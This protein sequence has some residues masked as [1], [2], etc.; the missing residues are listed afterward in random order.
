MILPLKRHSPINILFTSVGR[1][2]ELLRAFRRAYSV[3][4][5]E[6]IIVGVDLDTLAPALQIVHKGYIVP[7]VGSEDYVSTLEAICRREKIDVVLPLIDPDIPVL[8]RARPVLEATGAR[9]G[10]VSPAA[11]AVTADKWLTSQFFQNLGLTTPQS[12]LPE[13]MWEADVTYP[14]FIKPRAGSAGKYAFRVENRRQLEFFLDY[15]AEPIIQ[16]CIDGPEITSDVL[17]DLEGTLLGV[18]SRRRIEVRS[19]E[20]AKGVTIRHQPVID[21]CARIAREL[22]AVGPITV[23][24]LML[25]DVPCFTEINARFGGGVPLGIAAGF[26]VPL[27]LLSRCAGIPIAAPRLGEYET[28]LHITRCDESFFLTE[29][30]REQVAAGHSD[31]HR[32]PLA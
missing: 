7:P 15:V 19:G 8:S 23:Q 22:P 32:T 4:G 30:Q 1:R 31:T 21:A 16:E 9:V 18:V 24:C 12:W 17:C 5:L 11:A 25:G 6:G 28:G 14:L 3:L 10:V 27:L 2:V 20:V 26:D 13:E 29:Q